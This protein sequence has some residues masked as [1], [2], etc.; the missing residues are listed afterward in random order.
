M[1]G[2]RWTIAHGRSLR[3]L[4]HRVRLRRCAALRAGYDGAV[5]GVRVP[6]QGLSRKEARRSGTL[7]RARGGGRVG[8]GILVREGA[9]ARHPS[10]RDW[11]AG[12][13]VPWVGRAAAAG[14]HC[15][16]RAAVSPGQRSFRGNPARHGP[17]W[18]SS[19]AHERSSDESNARTP[20]GH[21]QARPTD[22]VPSA[23]ARSPAVAGSV[24]R[25]AVAA[26]AFEPSAAS[27]AVIEPPSARVHRTGAWRWQLCAD[28]PVRLWC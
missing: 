27:T 1:A 18:R 22:G 25:T 12:S 9:A 21:D 8:E 16:A 6:I 23:G 24:C 14:V 17:R 26:S 3:Q 11:T 13:L 15:R 4:W 10:T 20:P 7:D 19:R 28:A 5:H 2:R